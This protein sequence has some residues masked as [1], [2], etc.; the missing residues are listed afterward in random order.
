MSRIA[1][2][3]GEVITPMRRG[4]AGSGCLCAR[5][6]Q[7]LGGELL[8][9]FLE[10][11]PQRAFAGLL[12]VLDDQLVLAARLVEARPGRGPAP[13]RRRATGK[14]TSRLRWR[15]IAQRTWAAASLSEKY[16]CPE[17]GRDR[18]EISP[19]SQTEPRPRSSSSARLA[20]Q[21]ADGE[22]V[23][24]AAGRRR[25]GSSQESCMVAGV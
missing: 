8:L 13:A 20:V 19:S 12:E 2:P 25:G 23:A 7:A 6:E 15:N 1:A 17:A 5:V 24:R 10:A 4:R 16:Q 18:F 9:Q 3:V 14:R 22:D 21:A 11:A